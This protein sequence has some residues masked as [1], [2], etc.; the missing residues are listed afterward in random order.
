MDDAC[1]YGYSDCTCGYD[2]LAQPNS[3]G[4]Y[5]DGVSAP[6]STVSVSKASSSLLQA[7]TSLSR[8]SD[9]DGGDG[10]AANTT[11][12]TVSLSKHPFDV[13]TC[14]VH[15][16]DAHHLP[17]L[18]FNTLDSLVFTNTLRGK[19]HLRWQDK[20]DTGETYHGYTS[21]ADHE[22]SRVSITLNTAL[23]RKG[24]WK[25]DIFAALVHHMV[26]AYLLMRCGY[27]PKD[28]EQPSTDDYDL[29]HSLE[30]V[31]L[32]SAINHILVTPEFRYPELLACT[33]EE[34]QWVAPPLEDGF[35]K[36]SGKSKCNW[37]ASNFPSEREIR[38]CFLRLWEDTEKGSLALRGRK[39]S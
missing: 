27:H 34:D 36:K 22:D 32:L 2:E 11:T 20:Y 5:D 24:N 21:A 39:K 14:P 7:V 28:E 30:F 18:C 8:A 3:Y 38:A 35:V 12:E 16:L 9:G 23:Q 25:G 33:P 15:S 10:G 31:T 6:T 37:Y 4:S 19:V 13:P 1:D 17:F 26:H 29:S